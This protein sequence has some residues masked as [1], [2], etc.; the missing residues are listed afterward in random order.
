MIL[1]QGRRR[2]RIS[3]GY[4]PGRMECRRIDVIEFTIAMA[5]ERGRGAV[6]L[7]DRFAVNR[8]ETRCRRR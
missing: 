6:E 3:D 5:R 7:Y 4:M 8:S 2:L 1:E